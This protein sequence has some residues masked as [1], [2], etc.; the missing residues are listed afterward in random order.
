M[1]NS[2]GPVPLPS[3]A[4]DGWQ[5]D[6]GFN[7][8]LASNAGRPAYFGKC[9][10]AGDAAFARE[11]EVIERLSAAPAGR[12][13]LPAACGIRIGDARLQ[14]SV[15]LDGT[16]LNRLVRGFAVD[17]WEGALGEIIAAA[18]ALGLGAVDALA[19]IIPEPA[20][21]S[22]PDEGAS[23]L[24]TLAGA[25]VTPGSV[26]ALQRLLDA[27][28]QVRSR[29]QHGDLWASNVLRTKDQWVL[30][31]L[32]FFGMVR[33]PLYDAI[34][35][36]KTTSQMRTTPAEPWDAPRTPWSGLMLGETPEG[37]VA[38]RVLRS[39]ANANRLP[40]AAAVG[41][42]AFY[43]CD[44]TARLVSQATP[45]A[46]LDPVLQDLEAFARAL[47]DGVAFHRLLG[48]A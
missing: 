25:G 31:D 11:T 4:R 29:P 41:C 20:D 6:R 27:A 34:H 12:N 7:L 45:A 13:V 19:G 22:L 15:Y 28:P 38:R 30:L 8:L 47:R 3:A 46:L 26:E 44:A 33:V 42:A 2:V 17:R 10:D 36:V 39:A 21:L 43:L 5:A 48:F 16:P 35:L 18:D 9:R 32:E 23:A 24:A 14:L 1:V 40:T 37:G